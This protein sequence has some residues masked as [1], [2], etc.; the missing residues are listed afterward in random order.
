MMHPDDGAYDERIKS[1]ALGT[2]SSTGTIAVFVAMFQDKNIF[3]VM[4]STESTDQINGAVKKL[5]D[6]TFAYE[7]DRLAADHKKQGKIINNQHRKSKGRFMRRHDN[8][9]R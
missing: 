6:E 4:K 8:Q 5:L 3:L 7:T 1:A 2:T 9:R